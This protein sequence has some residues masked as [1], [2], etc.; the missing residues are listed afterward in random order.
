MQ[1]IIKEM[2]ILMRIMLSGRR[3]VLY[4]E[5]TADQKRICEEFGLEVGT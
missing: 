4:S 2:K 5:L 3:K 1:S